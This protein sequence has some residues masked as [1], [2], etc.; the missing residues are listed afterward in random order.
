LESL[1]LYP[2]GKGEW[3]KLGL[4][5]VR[6]ERPQDVVGAGVWQGTRLAA[7]GRWALASCVVAPEFVW[8]DFELGERSALG[9]TYPDFAADIAVL[10]RDRPAAGVK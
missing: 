7:G 8:S 6:D 9:V 10:T 3:V 1:R 4:N 2:D 5:L